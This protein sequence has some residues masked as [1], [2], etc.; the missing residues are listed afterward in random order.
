MY[1]IIKN[2]VRMAKLVEEGRL[3]LVMLQP[4]A[5]LKA[6]QALFNPA[7]VIKGPTPWDRSLPPAP[8]HDEAES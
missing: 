2:A 4:P 7:P 6:L 8:T 3:G 5:T 1:E